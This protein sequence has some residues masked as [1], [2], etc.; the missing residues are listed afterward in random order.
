V[1]SRNLQTVYKIPDVCKM[2][3]NLPKMRWRDFCDT[4]MYW[5]YL[6]Q[7]NKNAVPTKI[8][9]VYSNCMLGNAPAKYSPKLRQ[10]TLYRPQ[11]STCVTSVFKCPVTSWPNWKYWRWRFMADRSLTLPIWQSMHTKKVYSFCLMVEASDHGYVLHTRRI[12]VTRYR[13]WYDMI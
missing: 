8:Y 11:T 4:N 6:Q 3:L 2:Q 5:I 1:T 7:T 9:T 12:H 10:A 13:I